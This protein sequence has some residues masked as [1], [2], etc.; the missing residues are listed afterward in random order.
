VTG[1]AES[2]LRVER[3]RTEFR[4]PDGRHAA[5][6]DEVSFSIGRGETLGLVGESGSGKSVTALSIVRLLPPPGRIVRG[7][8]ELEG[9]NLLEIDE[10]D[11]PQIRGRRIGFIFQEPMA[12]LNPVYT[13]GYQIE[14]TLAVHDLARGAAAR[15]RALELLDAARIPE[16]QRRAKEYPHQLSGGLRQR[17]MIALA[18]A[19]DP[20][21]LIADEPTTALDVTVQAEILDLLRDMRRQFHLSL[22]LITHDFGVIAEMVDRVAVMYAGRIVEQAPVDRVF[23]SPAH[24]YT[25][26]LLACMPRLEGTTLAGSQTEGAPTDR[27]RRRRLSAIAGTVPALGDL[28]PGCAFAPRCPE[29]FDPCR[30]AAPPEVLAAPDQT[31]RCYLHGGIPPP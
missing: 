17:A 11:M 10:R 12:A 9:R 3:L 20:A 21:L 7:R 14:E 24:P 8:V 22:L 18:I 31:A 19:A 2:L 6:V 25:R 23:Q 15:R 5:A 27:S 30:A 13:I 1:P 26:G 16:P 29:R 28:P 4:L